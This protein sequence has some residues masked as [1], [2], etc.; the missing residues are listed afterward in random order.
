M[1]SQDSYLFDNQWQYCCIKQSAALF[2][3]KSFPKESTPGYVSGN[4]M[5]VCHSLIAVPSGF[6]L[7]LSFLILRGTPTKCLFCECL[8]TEFKEREQWLMDSSHHNVYAQPF[9]FFR[10]QAL[11]SL[12]EP[13][14]TMHW[15]Y[16]N[17]DL[18]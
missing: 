2:F 7:K 18:Q 4:N 6:Y 15:A 16:R 12:G 17:I 11:H 13:A 8:N 1:G 14:A 3:F 9:F 5:L 10:I